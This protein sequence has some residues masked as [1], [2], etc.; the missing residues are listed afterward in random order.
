M[1][2]FNTP[3]IN[4]NRTLNRIFNAQIVLSKVYAKYNLFEDYLKAFKI[5]TFKS[6]RFVSRYKPNRL[7]KAYSQIKTSQFFAD[8]Q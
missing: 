7:S 2:H 3:N 4:I 8:S 6:D 5:L 1:E